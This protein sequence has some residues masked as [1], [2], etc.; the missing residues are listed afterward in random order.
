[1]HRIYRVFPNKIF[2]TQ[3]AW[4]SYISQKDGLLFQIYGS[5]AVII[6]D[7][8]KVLNSLSLELIRSFTNLLIECDE[9][10]KI[11]VILVKGN[12]GKAFCSGGDI[13]SITDSA[14]KGGNIHSRFFLEEY[15]LSKYTIY[16]F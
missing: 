14:R 11:H 13:V 7:R 3:K 9:D 16:S 12:G 5:L 10:P 6:L 4:T 8:P 2:S 15:S 1:M